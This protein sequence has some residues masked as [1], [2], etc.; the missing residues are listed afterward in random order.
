[1]SRGQA[2][3]GW[4]IKARSLQG[5]RVSPCTGPIGN[6]GHAP[7]EEGGDQ[8][9]PGQCSS[10]TQTSP[11][12]RLVWTDEV[13]GKWSFVNLLHSKVAHFAAWLPPLRGSTPASYTPLPGTV[14]PQNPCVLDHRQGGWPAVSPNLSALFPGCAL[15]FHQLHPRVPGST[16]RSVGSLGL[17]DG[18]LKAGPGPL[19]DL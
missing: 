10:W 3:W 5:G 13:G 1:M 6:G 14:G 2:G 19:H 9:R 8:Q 7:D 16:P 17:G 4:G 15:S 12:R 18:G 11:G